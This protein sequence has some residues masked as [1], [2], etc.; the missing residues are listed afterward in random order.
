M[1]GNNSVQLQSC[2]ISLEHA[3]NAP[4]SIINLNIF[5]GTIVGIMSRGVS[6][7]SLRTCV[8]PQSIKNL[9]IF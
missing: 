4:K 9:N 2:K 5:Y 6:A 1:P 8:V 7:A 3:N